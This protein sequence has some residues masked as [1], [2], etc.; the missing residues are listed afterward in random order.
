MQINE[1][2]LSAFVSTIKHFRNQGTFGHNPTN[3]LNGIINH[4]GVNNTSQNLIKI[5]STLPNKLLN[6]NDV[7][8]ICNNVE[9]S[10]TYKVV[11]VFSWGGMRQAPGASYL[12]FRNWDNYEKDLN[13]IIQNLRTNIYSRNWA[14]EKLKRMNMGGCR[15]AYYTKLLFFF[16][17]GNTYIM[18][19]WTSKSIELLWNLND[20]IGIIFDHTCN[21]VQSSNHSGI[22]EEFCNRIELLTVIVNRQLNSNYTPTQIEE[23]IF[24]NGANNGQITGDWRAY[25]QANWR[26]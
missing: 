21:Y 13:Q 3:F 19:Q 7:F 22:Y 23:M 20:R 4:I 15:P 24:S 5:Q 10:L 1:T 17:N 12:F 11:C 26:C 25:V 9:L 2:H 18:D 14:Y 6:R 8:N 16:G